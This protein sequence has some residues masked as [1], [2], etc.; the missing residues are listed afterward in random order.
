MDGRIPITRRGFQALKSELQ[1][2]MS[3]ERPA[4]KRAIAEARAHGDLRENAEYHAAKEKQS[5]I[6]GRI[7]QIN[8]KLGLF[9]VV[10]P[11]HGRS[12]AIAFGAT[13]TLAF[14]ETE[15]TLQYQIVGPDEADIKANRISY[16]SPIARALIGKRSGDVVLVQVPK[17]QVEVEISAILYE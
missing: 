17:G 7:Q 8:A 10:E 4:I 14:V 9:Q 13:V 5:F 12:D 11:G 6:E 2:L 15:E 1:Q 16:Q 3:K